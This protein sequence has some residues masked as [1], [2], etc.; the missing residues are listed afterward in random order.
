MFQYLQFKNLSNIEIIEPTKNTIILCNNK[1]LVFGIAKEFECLIDE[2]VTGCKYDNIDYTLTNNTS[3]TV[4]LQVDLFGESLVIFNIDNREQRIIISTEISNIQL[5]QD[6]KDL[7]FVDKDNG[8]WECYALTDFK[9][10]VVERYKG[11]NI[12][13]TR[14]IK[15]GKFGCYEKYGL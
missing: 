8:I 12:R 13:L 6:V 7:W 11:D 5:I 4:N 3:E 1:D 14:A 15:Q 9:K 10:D 2:L